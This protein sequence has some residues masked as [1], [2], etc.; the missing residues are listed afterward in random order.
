[1]YRCSSSELVLTG[2]LRDNYITLIP[3]FLPRVPA[4]C[5]QVTGLPG[6][7][8]VRT[9]QSR[10]HVAGPPAALVRPP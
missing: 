7:V 3:R 10:L 5:L 2:F 6:A 1:M 4:A 9:M 8:L